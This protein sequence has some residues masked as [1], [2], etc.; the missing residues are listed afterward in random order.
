MLKHVF[1]WLFANFTPSIG[2]LK[3]NMWH[4]TYPMNLIFWLRSWDTM[5]S[6][7]VSDAWLKSSLQ[8]AATLMKPPGRTINPWSVVSGW[9]LHFVMQSRNTVQI[10]R[11]SRKSGWGVVFP[12]TY[13]LYIYIQRQK[14]IVCFQIEMWSDSPQTIWFLFLCYLAP[15]GRVHFKSGGCER[16][17]ATPRARDSRHLA[18]RNEDGPEELLAVSWSWY[19]DK[20]K[21]LQQ[22]FFIDP[23][24]RT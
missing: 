24:S 8:V 17:D 19:S 22:L 10:G 13:T 23:I 21:T 18:H 16:A 3:S 2:S 12:Q 6:G 15:W 1:C 20:K 11:T 5:H 7:C 14:Q 9:S 4:K